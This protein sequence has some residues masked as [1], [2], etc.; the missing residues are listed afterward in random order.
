MSKTI[1]EKI[2]PNRMPKQPF[3]LKAETTLQRATFTPSTANPGETLYINIPK[4]SGDNVIV[5]NSVRLAFDLELLKA[6]ANDTVVNNLGRNLIHSFKAMLGGETLQ[7]T[8]RYDLFSTFS[9]S[10]LSKKER[11]KRIRQGIS[12]VNMRKLRTGAGDATTSD[13]GQVSLG[14][15][16]GKRYHIPIN[17]PIL[18]DHGVFRPAS[19]RETLLFEIRLAPVFDIVVTSDSSKGQSYQLKNMELEYTTISSSHLAQEAA[20][21][22]VSGKGFYYENVHLKETFEISKPDDSVINKHINEPRRSMSGILLLFNDPIT[23]GA[24]DSEKFVNPALLT[25]SVNI[26]GLPNKLYSK[27]MQTTDFYD[28]MMKRMEPLGGDI[29]YP[30][31]FYAG[32]RFGLWIDLRTFPDPEIHGGGFALD[33]ISDGVKLEMRRKAGGTGKVTCYV[34]IV[35]DAIAEVMNG[36]LSSIMYKKNDVH[37]EAYVSETNGR[38]DT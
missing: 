9:D 18:D 14:K 36:G 32:D 37:L 35:S 22:Y 26:N 7:D 25:V 31:N 28:S 33:N 24:R 19:L 13:A 30:S 6:E 8:N 27:S 1:S 3:G 17:H 15:I 21:A 10:F 23:E 5:P 2:D 38:A 16:Y 29:I 20:G 11:T 12:A 4:L 34:F